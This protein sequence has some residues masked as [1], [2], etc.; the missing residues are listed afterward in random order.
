MILIIPFLITIIFVIIIIIYTSSI[1]SINNSKLS[2]FSEGNQ[3]LNTFSPI[4][5]ELIKR[6]IYF[7]YY[8]LDNDDEL[9]DLKNEYFNPHFLGV[10]ILG[11]LRFKKIST[12]NLLSTTPNI[13]N[14][15]FPLKRP[16]KVDNLI[17]VWHSISDIGYYRKGSLD[18]YDT[19]LNVGQFQNKSIEAIKKIRKT[20]IQKL[21]PVGLPY[22]DQFV[23]KIKQDDSSTK[24]I[25]IGSS[26]GDKGLLKNHGYRV[27]DI[28]KDRKIIIRPHPQSFF[29]EKKFIE[30]FKSKCDSMQNVEWD[31]SNNPLD[32]F[33]NA[34]ILISDTSSIRYDFSFLTLKPVITLKINNNYL[35]EYECNHLKVRWKNANIRKN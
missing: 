35:Q 20:N 1:P 25:L 26:W 13:G 8:T 31:D 27:L 21:I 15:K 30:D 2:V 5:K 18:N 22:Y 10:G 7:N 24:S 34:S 29:S 23:K 12:E 14:K 19:I 17:H 32:S 33:R 11:H 6:K 16:K 9:L 4:V 3:Y 28:L